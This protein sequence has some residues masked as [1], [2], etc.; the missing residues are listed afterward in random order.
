MRIERIWARANKH[1]FLIKPIAL[2]LKEEMVGSIWVDPFCG[3]NS[4][5][6]YTNDLNPN[7][8]QAQFHL[9]ALEHLKLF[10]NSSVDGVLFDPP[11]SVT[12]LKI[13]YENIGIALTGKDSNFSFWT[14]IK[15][16]MA[17][18]IKVNGRCISFGWN[19][20][21]LG[22]SRG[23]EI[24]RILLVPHGSV[25]NDTIVTVDIKGVING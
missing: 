2:L 12:Q 9:D 10:P 21:G 16:Q 8:T 5:A 15:D 25:R 7:I 17:R 22:K 20:G 1:T 24:I 19:T 18:I 13:C 11:Y 4:P 6:S 3:E 23:F 14:R